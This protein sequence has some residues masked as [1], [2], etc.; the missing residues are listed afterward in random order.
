VSTALD[1]ARAVLA[2]ASGVTALVGTK[3]YPVHAPQG[4][5]PP[6]VVM[7]TVSDVPLHSFT[8]TVD[9]RLTNARIQID[10]YAKLYKDANAIATAVEAA[11]ELASSPSLS[12]MRLN[13]LDLYDDETELYRVSA[14]FSVWR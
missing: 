4:S 11:L 13:K 2:A 6:F 14:D 5:V 12:M 7:S 3:L 9:D 10:C 8:N 1:D